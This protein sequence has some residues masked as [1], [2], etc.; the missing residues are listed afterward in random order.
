[1]TTQNRDS[2]AASPLFNQS[3][4]KGIAVLQAFGAMRR[5]MTL[6]EI[7]EAAAISKSSAQ[8]S[9]YTLETL[10]L[11]RKNA[12]T[13]RFELTPKVMSIGCN[14]LEADPLIDVANSFLAT[15]G[16]TCN[17]TTS[18]TEPEGLEM[19][20]VARFPTHNHIPIHIPIGRRLPMFCTASGRAYLFAL[21]EQEAL[22]IL[23]QSNRCMYTPH[24]CT[25]IDALMRMLAEARARGYAYNNQEYYIGDLNVAAPILN[26][27]GRPVA[28]IHVA[29]PGG[30]WQLQEA[31]EKLGPQVV[32]CARAISNAARALA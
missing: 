7:A 24:T 28:S 29:A 4:E 16:S 1:M 19:V 2:A 11:L 32:E 26:S 17:E 30:R 8:R 15:L 12:V 3:L 21:P 18:L 13:K 20:Y 5:S 22:D 25:D 23:Q 6:V 10:G 14:Y 27:H 31:T 9:V